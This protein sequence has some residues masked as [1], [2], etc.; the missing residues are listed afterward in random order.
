MLVKDEA[1]LVEASVRYTATQVDHLIVCDNGSTDGTFEI[2]RALGEEFP[3]ELRADADPAYYQARKMTE[4]AEYARQMGH[5]WVVPVDVDELWYSPDG[6]T[7]AE[8]LGG[9]APDIAY[10][11][12]TLYNHL[13][14]ALDMPERCDCDWQEFR[15]HPGGGYP[16]GCDRCFATGGEPNPFRRIGWRQREH[17]ALPKVAARAREGLE[18]R[19]GNHSA[20]A[21]GTG[22][23][24]T[25]LVVRHFSW[26]TADQYVRKIA[27]GYRAY[28]A[29]D[30][31]EDVGAHWRMFGDPDEPT[32]EE[33]VRAHF[34]QWFFIRDP[35]ADSSLIY[36]PAPWHL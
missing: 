18:I 4:L 5:Q 13:P 25:A 14:T 15:D 1:D 26:R 23:T 8:F 24:I 7:L 22:L 30:L 3:F 34:E 29:T 9:L 20:Y 17:G 35:S 10:V 31:S 27:N 16:P 19:Q 12:A 6:R 2:L 32:F 28:A 11:Q 36:D 33:R 21:P